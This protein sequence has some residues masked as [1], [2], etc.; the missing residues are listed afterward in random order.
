MPKN[1]KKYSFFEK[2]ITIHF[3]RRTL[4]VTIFIIILIA[5]LMFLLGV[6]TERLWESK[7][8]SEEFQ[9]ELL[10]PKQNPENNLKM[11]EENDEVFTFYE[12]LTKTE[13]I[14]ERK[15]VDIPKNSS[16]KEGTHRKKMVRENKIHQKII[17]LQVGAFKNAEAADRLVKNLKKKGY[18]AEKSTAIIP[19][20]GLWHRVRIGTFNN[21]GDALDLK[22]QLKSENINAV[23]VEKHKKDK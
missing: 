3:S 13:D 12:E 10:K 22:K 1:R 15:K 9:F 6:F 7:K 5:W 14:L 4:I 20:K 21:K 23:L 11:G 16:T 2:E 19:D 8:I 17:T 18:P